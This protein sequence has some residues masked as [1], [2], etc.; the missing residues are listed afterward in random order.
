[1]IVLDIETTG[2]DPQVNGIVSLGAIDF[3]HPE[4]VFSAECRARDGI[5]IDDEALRINGF[6]REQILD[7][8]KQSEQ[9]AYGGSACVGVCFN[10]AK[11]PSCPCKTWKF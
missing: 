10:V 5:E 9:E 4:R 3:L 6:T 2:A 8:S 7:T 1:M 11:Q